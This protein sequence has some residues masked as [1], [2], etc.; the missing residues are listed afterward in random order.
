VEELR[1]GALARADDLFGVDR[2]PWCVEIF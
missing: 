1:D 2:A